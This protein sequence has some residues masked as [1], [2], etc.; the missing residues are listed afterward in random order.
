MPPDWIIGDLQDLVRKGERGRGQG[1]QPGRLLVAR[2][3]APRAAL[4]PLD[5]F[6]PTIRTINGSPACDGHNPGQAQS[7]VDTYITFTGLLGVSPGGNTG[8]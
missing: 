6:G 4:P 2:G 5:T 1:A 7:R 3:A 8:C